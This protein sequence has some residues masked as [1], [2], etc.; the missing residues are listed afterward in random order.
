VTELSE[1]EQE[2]LAT[3]PAEE[4]ESE[5]PPATGTWRDVADVGT[6]EARVEWAEAARTVLIETA[7]T[8]RAVLLFKE[9]AAEV[10]YRTGV[11]TKQPNHYWISDVLSRVSRECAARDEP[12]LSTLC[13]NAEGSVGPAYGELVR[14]LT[15]EEAADPDQHAAEQRLACY[16]RYDA[17]GLPADGGSPALAPKLSDS[18]SRARKAARL[19]KPV[20][21]CP[22]CMMALLPTGVCDT[23][24]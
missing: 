7:G 2:P 11:R 12:L 24:D 4:P 10:Q 18:R 17:V 9:L 13:V 5:A 23:C 3:E 6:E 19:A 16:R 1:V 14:E 8:Y 22:K 15:G 20:A 21:T